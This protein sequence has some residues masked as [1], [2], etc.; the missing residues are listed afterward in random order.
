M[1]SKTGSAA[2]GAD[3]SKW[4]TGKEIAALRD[5]TFRAGVED[6]RQPRTRVDRAPPG[7]GP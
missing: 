7:R 4:Y 6:G 3:A 5:E 1:S 2:D